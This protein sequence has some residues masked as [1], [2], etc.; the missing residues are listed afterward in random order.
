MPAGEKETVLIAAFAL[1]MVV[2][3]LLWAVWYLLGLASKNLQQRYP[4]LRTT[5]FALG[6]VALLVWFGVT[7]RDAF[8]QLLQMLR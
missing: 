7:Y 1:L 3:M 2:V 4:W 8:I 5:S 6:V